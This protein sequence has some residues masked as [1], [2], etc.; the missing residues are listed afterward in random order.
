MS[1]DQC[2]STNGLNTDLSR[3]FPAFKQVKVFSDCDR[4]G[5]VECFISVYKENLSVVGMWCSYRRA[6]GL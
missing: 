6:D 4:F 2:L 3:D 1:K 5:N